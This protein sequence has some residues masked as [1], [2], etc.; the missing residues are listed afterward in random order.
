MASPR[1]GASAPGGFF[2]F[3]AAER[4]EAGRECGEGRSHLGV[5]LTK[6]SL[7]GS[8]TDKMLKCVECGTDFTYAASEQELH[9]SLGY[10]N[11]PKRCTPCR[12]AKR[13]RKAGGGRG[14]P[15][16]GPRGG[17]EIGRASW[18]ERV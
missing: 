7:M 10:Q 14:G 16:A 15:G 1:L 17:G 5:L 3:A 4:K 12:D 9:A 13:Q 6:G 2:C 8:Y 18:R 11:E